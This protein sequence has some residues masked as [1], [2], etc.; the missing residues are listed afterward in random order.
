MAED[1]EKIKLP[2]AGEVA[3]TLLKSFLNSKTG[4]GPQIT[5]PQSFEMALS[6]NTEGFNVTETLYIDQPNRRLRA[7]LSY[8]LLGLS[9]TTLFDLTV[10][11]STQRLA[12][13][14]ND[15]CKSMPALQS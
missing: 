6:T 10:D 9:E 8:S 5:W 1:E 12:F 14:T 3:T 11:D 7:K 2:P 4:A 13:K 15:D